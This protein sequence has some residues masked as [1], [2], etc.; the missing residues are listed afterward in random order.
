[1]RVLGDRASTVTGG[2]TG[3]RLVGLLDVKLP[4]LLGGHP[5]S[6]GCRLQVRCRSLQDKRHNVDN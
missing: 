3:L 1:M 4:A 6:R 5:P 2:N